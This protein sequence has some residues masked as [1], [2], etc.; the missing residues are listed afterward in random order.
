[1]Q[2]M[3]AMPGFFKPVLPAGQRRSPHQHFRDGICL[4]ALRAFTGAEIYRDKPE[5]L[6]LGE[7]ALRVGSNVHY[8]RAAAVLLE[9]GDQVL[10]KRVLRGKISILAAAASVVA[11]VKLLAAFKTASP[12]N[13]ARFYAITGT[14]DLT[15]TAKRTE[16]ASKLGPEIVWEEMVVPL[17]STD[18]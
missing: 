6:T 14:A 17:V 10:I 3:A 9:H 2:H 11:L 13:L 16:A 5:E 8:I 15:T 1:M 4:A 12:E 7:V 18:H